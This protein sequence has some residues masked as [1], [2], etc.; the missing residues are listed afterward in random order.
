MKFANFNSF[1]EIFEK[2]GGDTEKI[3]REITREYIKKH[4][5]DLQIDSKTAFVV[6][7]ADSVAPMSD[8]SV[9]IK[10]ASRELDYDAEVMDSIVN[11]ILPYLGKK[12]IDAQFDLVWDILK[13][14]L[15]R[16]SGDNKAAFDIVSKALKHKKVNF[17]HELGIKK[18]NIFENIKEALGISGQGV[19]QFLQAVYQINVKT[20]AQASG[21]GEYLIDLFVINARKGSDVSIDDE[22]FEIKAV[23][24]AIGETIG[25]K[26]SYNEKLSG[27]FKAAGET[28]EYTKMSFSKE[29][30]K[31][32][33]A[34]EFVNFTVKHPESAKEFL[35]YQYKFYLQKENSD[36][37]KS[38]GHY[39][40]SPSKGDLAMLYDK[41]CLDY[42][43]SALYVN[44]KKQA[45]IIFEEKDKLGTGN[46]ILLD[47]DS[48]DNAISFAGSYKKTAVNISLPKSSQTIR[49][50]VE[51]LN[52]EAVK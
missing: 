15:F 52:F 49:P 7:A 47:Y 17:D 29:K 22:H 6:K 42:V 38:V 46:Y 39:I 24:G 51:S 33:W 37:I 23:H 28:L 30:F 25:G 44:G 18:G 50:E 2:F 12:K 1:K 5:N 41:L 43:K 16:L 11:S 4:G 48:I 45:L 21:K 3:F 9:K 40:E 8:P 10:K 14:A 32:V 35:E 20:G 26:I 36:F 31:Q 27:I 19:D 13:K 34:P